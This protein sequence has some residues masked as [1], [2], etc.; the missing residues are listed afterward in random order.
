MKMK[1]IA[2]AIAASF[3]F[4][5]C[6]LM[7]GHGRRQVLLVRSD[8]P[9]ATIIT[10]EGVQGVT[11]K[12]ILISRDQISS[13]KLEDPSGRQE[14]TY[15]L[16]GRYRWQDSFVPNLIFLSYAPVGWLVD[17]LTKSAW[18]LQDPPVIELKPWPAPKEKTERVI[19]IAPP[20]ADSLYLAD[21]V[22]ANLENHARRRYPNDTIL[23]YKETVRYFS[24][25]SYDFDS[26]PDP[27]GWRELHYSLKATHLLESRVTDE[28]LSFKVETAL[29]DV[30]SR[31]EIDREDLDMKLDDDSTVTAGRKKLGRFFNLIPNTV[32]VDFSNRVSELEVDG[33]KYEAEYESSDSFMEKSYKYLGAIGFSY[34]ARPR[35]E[36]GGTWKFS[37][38]PLVS[39]SYRR[40]RFSGIPLV[41]DHTFTRWDFVAGVGPELGY[42][43]GNSYTYVNYIPTVGWTH[44]TWQ[45]DN[46]DHRLTRYPFSGAVEGGYTYFLSDHIVLRAFARSFTEDEELWREVISEVQ[47]A[48]PQVNSARNVLTGLSIG[49]HFS[50]TPRLRSLSK[51][52]TQNR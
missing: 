10:R 23:P 22:A 35:P 30:Y 12:Y 29:W 28:H 39:G 51:S 19:A 32:R 24:K 40:M 44:M 1:G 43:V 37:F 41:E 4:T 18:Q 15:P 52:Q 7:T 26:R 34:M 8:P 13:L 25:N 27:D 3:L 5:G 11:P 47:G 49:Y 42:Q 20:R 16:S 6:A 31:A 45:D 33:E 17:L 14:K 9:G 50:T 36:S 46:G 21:Q 48:E 38:V 2:A